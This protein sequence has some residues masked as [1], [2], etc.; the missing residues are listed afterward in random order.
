MP[1]RMDCPELA[2]LLVRTAMAC[3]RRDWGLAAKAVQK[4]LLAKADRSQKVLRA[5]QMLMS[6]LAVTAVR[7]LKS[8]PVAKADRM[9]M[10]DPVAKVGRM[11][12]FDPV[13]TVGRRLTSDLVA[14][15]DQMQMAANVLQTLQ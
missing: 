10:I 9:L 6:G 8:G 3:F 14:R 5:G 12:T 13:A 7:R 1:K 4:R 2:S 15:A 11:L